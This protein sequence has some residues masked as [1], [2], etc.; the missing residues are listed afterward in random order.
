MS[1]FA[2]LLSA[3]VARSATAQFEATA[4]TGW[5]RPAQA[6]VELARADLRTKSQN[7][8]VTLTVETTMRL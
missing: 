2:F 6:T 7:R 1:L 8:Q 5:Q 3:F 4:W